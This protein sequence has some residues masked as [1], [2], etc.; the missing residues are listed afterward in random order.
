MAQS[1]SS[2]SATPPAVAPAAKSKGPTPSTADSNPFPTA[3]SEAAQKPAQTSRDAAS[4]NP[5]PEAESQAAQT[6]ANAAEKPQPPAADAQDSSSSRTRFKGVDL[7]GNSDAPLSDGAGHTLSDPKRGA[8]DVRVGQLY[9]AEGDYT[10]AYS[11]FKEATEVAP[12]NAEAVF[13]LAE[14][15]R[16]TSH[17]DEAAENYT[18]Y[19]Q[20]EPNGRRAKDARKALAQLS[21]K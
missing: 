15:A 6:Q 13:Y 18:L 12:G 7:L 9:M 8:E 1:T 19:L 17:L 5:F 21:G 11:R 4:S 3:E 10:G 14:A 2:N 16:K 20:V